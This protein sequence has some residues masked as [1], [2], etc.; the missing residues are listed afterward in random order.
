MENS[1]GSFKK[2]CPQSPLP[3]PVSCLWF[4]SGISHCWL[5]VCNFAD[6]SQLDNNHS[7]SVRS[8]FF[9]PNHS[10]CLPKVQEGLFSKNTFHIRG[11]LFSKMF[12]GKFMPRRI[13]RGEG[14]VL[15]VSLIIS[16]SDPCQGRGRVLQKNGQMHFPFS[17]NLNTENLKTFPN[18]HH[19]DK[20]T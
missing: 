16:K 4:F 2:V 13:G 20:F 1:S 17:S 7:Q 11:K 12:L 5:V 10:V 8:R 14:V 18:H 19:G 6:S 9:L 3:P 15:H